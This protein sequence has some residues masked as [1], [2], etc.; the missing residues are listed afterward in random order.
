M[1][2]QMDQTNNQSGTPEINRVPLMIV[3][4]SGAFVAILNQTLLATAL[5]HIM[6][7]L[8]L[9]ANT[10]QWLQ[11]VFML[12]NGIMIPITAFLIER[13]TTRRLF[14]TALITFAAGTLVCALAPNF[15][16]LMVGRILQAAAAGIIMPLM[17]T[18]LFLIFPIEKR[19]S[20]MGMFGLVIAFAP[21]I[22]PTLSGW[23]VEHYPWRSLFYVILPIVIIDIFV[24]YFILKNITKQTFPKVDVLSIIL[25]SFG[26]G[27]LLYGFSTAGNSGWL[28][29]QVAIA[30]IVGAV[31]LTWFILRQMKLKQPILEFR[32]FKNSIFTLT[33][34]LGMVVF[35]AM[36]GGAVVL[37]LLM[38]NMLGFS[39]FESGLMLL[40][41]AVVMGIMNPITGRI[42][43]RYGAK[44]LAII[45]LSIVTVT[46]FMFTN[47]DENTTFA[48]LAT[49]NAVRMFGIAMVMMPVTTA[50]L[51][52]LPAHL[53]PHGTAMN[54]TMRQV[55]GAVGTALLVTVMTNSAI[56]EQGVHGFIHGVNV[57]FIVAGV[58]AVIALILAFFIKGSRSEIKQSA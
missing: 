16:M 28:S 49:V 43:D 17:Q 57:S 5:P 53:I 39:A 58:F 54:N 40:P 33:T 3:L 27:G 50:G 52:Q 4:I 18:I 21:A 38:Q 26:F 10:A 55:A 11:S 6:A 1:G 45:G 29:L 32:V 41:G 47:L 20:A 30:M 14:L 15:A 2:D 7:D 37:P 46:T 51:N 44:W 31:S 13:F 23:L 12:V 22:G 8:E 56:P 24:A 48:Y 19:G 36:I 34:I 9:D 42:F 25:S 35:M